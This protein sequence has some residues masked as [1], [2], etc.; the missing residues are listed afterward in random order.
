MC[1]GTG[2][3]ARGDCRV[4]NEHSVQ[5]DPRTDRNCKSAQLLSRRIS[6]AYLTHTPRDTVGGPEEHYGRR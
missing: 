3:Y 6:D 1:A 4:L 5:V 2:A